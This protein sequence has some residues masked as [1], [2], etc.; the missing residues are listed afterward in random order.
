MA[1]SSTRG[2]QVKRRINGDLAL[3][4]SVDAATLSTNLAGTNNDI[5]YTAKTKGSYGN[6]ITVAYVVAGNN[7][8]LS[9]DVTGTAITVNVAT[10]AGGA[11]TSTADDIKAAIEADADA[12]ALVTVA[13]KAANDGSGVVTALTATALTG[14]GGYTIGKS[15]SGLATRRGR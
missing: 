12:A 4:W 2:R 14:G 11:A 10:G 3:G 1:I 13:D 8:P 5:V 6:L 7:T 9:V 15:G